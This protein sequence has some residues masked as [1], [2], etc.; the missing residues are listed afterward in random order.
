M[1]IHEIKV[2]SADTQ[3]LRDAAFAFTPTGGVWKSLH[4]LALRL[5]TI[6]AMD[7]VQECFLYEYLDGRKEVRFTLMSKEKANA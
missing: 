5:D 7:D 4:E 3:M 1:K 6:M 2:T